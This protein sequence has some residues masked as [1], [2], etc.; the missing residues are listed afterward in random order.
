M[1]G[2]RILSVLFCATGSLTSLGLSE[3]LLRIRN[4]G[5]D[6]VQKRTKSSESK[7]TQ[8]CIKNLCFLAESRV[9][10]KLFNQP[11]IICYST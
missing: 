6:V 1:H 2:E 8:I 9:S 10:K 11:S 5:H 4:N 7:K 3:T